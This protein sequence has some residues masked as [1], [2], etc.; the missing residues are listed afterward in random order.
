[1]K[2][3]LF[4]SLGFLFVACAH[5][6]HGPNSI[7]AVHSKKEVDIWLKDSN[8]IIGDKVHFYREDCQIIA[9][10]KRCN[11]KSVGKGKV[12]GVI[13]NSRYSV[14]VAEGSTLDEHVS[15]EKTP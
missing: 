9:K 5:H 1:M 8:V 15:V 2:N 13:G 14:D 12:T 11:K 3:T 6:D 4:L 7:V 10:I